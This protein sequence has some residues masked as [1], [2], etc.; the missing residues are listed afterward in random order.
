MTIEPP[1]H[2]STKSSRKA[3]RAARQAGFTR[4]GIDL[5]Q[6][7]VRYID[8]FKTDGGYS[9]RGAAISVMLNDYRYL[10]GTM[11]RAPKQRKDALVS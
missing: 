11:R 8:Q 5:H 3:L 2:P 10:K 7:L 4:L 9:N 6:E 1:L